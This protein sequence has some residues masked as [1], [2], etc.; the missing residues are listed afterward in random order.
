MLLGTR[1]HGRLDA[2]AQ[3]LNVL[4]EEKLGGEVSG[5]FDLLEPDEEAEAYILTDYKTT[6]SFRVAQWLGLQGH[7]VPDSTGSVYKTSGTWGKAGSL[8]MV[9]Q[10]TADSSRADLWSEELQLNNYRLMVEALGFPVSRMRLQVTVRDGG[11]AIAENRGVAENIYLIPVKRLEDGF[12]HLYFDVKRRQ[13]LAALD[14]HILPFPCN[15][16]ESWDGRRCK[17]YCDPWQS[18]DVGVNA[19]RKGE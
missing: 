11:T 18:C 7:K 9:T 14:T 3:K 5:I 1:H 6:G 13:L 8:K 19:H 15:A 4:S 10:W 2:I 12:V 16:K 17:G